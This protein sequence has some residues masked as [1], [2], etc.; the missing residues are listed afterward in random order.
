MAL[1]ARTRVE[2]QFTMQGN[3][4]RVLEIY[5]ECLNSDEENP[6]GAVR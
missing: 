2:A 5:R 3:A 4:N 6:V 1:A